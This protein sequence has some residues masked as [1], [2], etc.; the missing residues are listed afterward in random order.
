MTSRAPSFIRV[1]FSGYLS[2]RDT[3]LLKAE[4][5]KA[6]YKDKRANYYYLPGLIRIGILE[7]STTKD[8]LWAY[9][10]L[11]TIFA[12]LSGVTVFS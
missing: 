12:L 1:I 8:Q 11:A 4:R 3:L 7:G 5:I 10:L 9:T 6:Y 2:R